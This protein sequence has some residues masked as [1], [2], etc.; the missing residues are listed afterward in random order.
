[1]IKIK[2]IVKKQDENDVR[3]IGLEKTFCRDLRNTKEFKLKVQMAEKDLDHIVTTHSRLGRD[4]QKL[5]ANIFK[6]KNR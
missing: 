3:K 6:I 1:M 4:F 5:T 2:N